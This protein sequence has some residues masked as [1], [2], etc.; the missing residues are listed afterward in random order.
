M[1]YFAALLCIVFAG[2]FLHAESGEKYVSALI[3][4]GLASLCFV[5]VGALCSP[6]TDTAKLILWGLIIGCI[7]DVL[8]NLRFV[9]VKK[10]QP[11]FLF[12]ILVFLAGHIMYLAAVLPLSSN[13]AICIAAG[14]ILTVLLMVWIFRHITAKPVFKVFGVVYIGAITLLNCV[15]AGILIE[16]PS[17]FRCVF[18]AGAVL[19][20]VSDILLTLNTFGKGFR[21]SLRLANLSLYYAGQLLIAF[22]LMLLK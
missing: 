13:P 8:L 9:F 20:L 21:R 18:A 22:S 4:K 19:F 12:G 7:A 11:I 3:F 16:V 1:A 5:A 6:G 17:A 14:I 10:G 15:A 2:F